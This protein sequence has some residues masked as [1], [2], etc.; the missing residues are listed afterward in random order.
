V[1]KETTT[2]T[3]VDKTRK[4]QAENERFLGGRIIGE[5]KLLRKSAKRNTLRKKRRAKGE[6]CKINSSRERADRRKMK[7]FSWGKKRG[8]LAEALDGR[9]RASIH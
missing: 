2:K 6:A 4:E 3:E 7:E 9:D 5:A 8:K 1:A